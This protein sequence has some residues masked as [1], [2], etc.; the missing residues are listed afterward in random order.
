MLGLPNRNSSLRILLY[1][2]RN[3]GLWKGGTSCIFSISARWPE[4]SISSLAVP[5]TNRT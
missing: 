4:F 1:L 5:S 2:I 3:A